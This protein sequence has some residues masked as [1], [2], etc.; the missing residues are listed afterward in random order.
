MFSDEDY[1]YKKF[2]DSIDTVI[3]GRKTYE[4]ALKSEEYP[5]KEKNC[6]IL[7]KV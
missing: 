2:Y 4:K 7:Q 5:F 1:G 6:D 3:M